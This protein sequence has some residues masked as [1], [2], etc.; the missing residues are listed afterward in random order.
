M[1]NS[2]TARAKLASGAA[3]LGVDIDEAMQHGTRYIT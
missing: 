2:G 1:G 3:M